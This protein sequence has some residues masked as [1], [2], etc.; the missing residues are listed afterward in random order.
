M[1][2]NLLGKNGEKKEI[3]EEELKKLRQQF[4]ELADEKNVQS[5]APSKTQQEQP[6]NNSYASSNSEQ[7]NAEQNTGSQQQQYVDPE[8]LEE[9]ERITN[10]IMQQIKELIEIDNN[11]NVK[12]KE[13]ET[14]LRN[15]ISQTQ[16]V[17]NVVD[18][19]HQRL[20]FIEKNMEKF[21]GLYE[22]VTN[23]FN[24]FVEEEQREKIENPNAKG[25]ISIPDVGLDEENEGQ[26]SVT[27]QEAKQTENKEP[28]A[29]QQKTNQEQSTQK[30]EIT[31]NS[32]EEL[33]KEDTSS[34]QTQASQKPTT[35]EESSEGKDLMIE[36]GVKG[37]LGKEAEEKAIEHLN[38][39]ISNIGENK[40]VKL[41]LIDKT[42]KGINK[43]VV[44]AIKTHSKVSIEQVDELMGGI[45]EE[46]GIQ[47]QINTQDSSGQKGK[48][49][50]EQQQPE[51]PKEKEGQTQAD[52]EQQPIQEEITISK[53]ENQKEHKEPNQETKEEEEAESDKQ[54]IKEQTKQNETSQ[55]TT[56]QEQSG[57]EEE[58]TETMTKK[59]VSQEL[60]FKTQ[61]GTEIKSVAD[62][63]EALKN[64]DDNEFA[65]HIT[66]DGN[67]FALWV[68]LA[69]NDSGIGEKL[70]TI[71]DKQQLISELE[72][73]D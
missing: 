57:Q 5:N 16:D 9:N 3:D 65:Q 27:E 54:E 30:E 49:N 12:I 72:K 51:Q 6:Q 50:E 20:E 37:K 26:K 25:N 63:R 56:S 70:S 36:A 55:Q 17:K 15:N 31:E 44:D 19:F 22:V 48:E 68:G 7:Q 66:E 60:H 45:S 21:M 2:E 39:I 4:K 61:D 29:E 40:Q 8:R 33:K 35:Q 38:T 11:L 14:K 32:S 43:L 10:L 34:T 42:A 69:L 23:R 46:L 73:I 71:K 64:M 47:A 62:L 18:K 52:S 41:K 28:S 67:D 59:E 13:I 24:P 58:N 53:N 1:F